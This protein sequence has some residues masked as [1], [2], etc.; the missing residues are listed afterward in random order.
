MC[1]AALLSSG[2]QPLWCSTGQLFYCVQPSNVYISGFRVSVAKA[3]QCSSSSSSNCLVM[4]YRYIHSRKLHSCKQAPF[5]MG[6]AD[7]HSHVH[8]A[9]ASI[10]LVHSPAEKQCHLT[11][12]TMLMHR[13]WQ[14]CCKITFRGTP[15][16]SAASS[17]GM[18]LFFLTTAPPWISSCASCLFCSQNSR[19]RPTAALLPALLCYRLQVRTPLLSAVHAD[20]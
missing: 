7:F 17:A 1:P 13:R 11:T 5:N 3:C 20:S 6:S 8:L 2:I 15:A 9:V 12:C 18:L 19:P 16:W 4:L 14:D 10:S